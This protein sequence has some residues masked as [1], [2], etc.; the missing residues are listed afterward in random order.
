MCVFEILFSICMVIH[1][2]IA[3][4]YVSHVDDRPYICLHIL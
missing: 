2:K 3:T 1:G 4:K